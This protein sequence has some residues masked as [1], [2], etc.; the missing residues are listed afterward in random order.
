MEITIKTNNNR[1]GDIYSNSV[2]AQTSK[3]TEVITSTNVETKVVKRQIVGMIW[4]DTNENGIKDEGESYANRIEVELKKSDGSKAVDVN[5]N[6]VQ[7]VLTNG[8]GEYQFSNL[9]KGEYI[10][11]IKTEDKYKLTS[12]NVGSNK[13][14][15]S[16]F[17][18]TEEGTKQSYVITNLNTIDS[19]EIIEKNVNA[20]LVVKD[21]KIIIKYLE[22]DTTPE[23]DGDNKVLKE[24]EEIT[25]YE[26]EGELVKYKIGDSYN[27]EKADITNYICLRNS[28]NTEGTIND[29]EIVVTYYYTYNKQDI[30]IQK[31]WNDNK[32]EAGK[33]PESIKV[34]LK[35]GNK[36]IREEILSEDNKKEIKDTKSENENGKTNNNIENNTKLYSR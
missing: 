29:E 36:V 32:N 35:D 28:G 24:Q 19:P 31:V 34:E 13:E 11:E 2:T 21:A 23:T 16:K 26:K 5:G 4:Y 7:N 9:P 18:E 3:S 6:E 33:R 30:T 25:E 14:I 12:A 27:T 1:S 20:G 22:E 10:V 8:E 15:N 17:E